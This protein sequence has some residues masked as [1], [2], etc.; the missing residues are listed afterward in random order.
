M[1]QRKN[2][3]FQ[4]GGKKFTNV[5]YLMQYALSTAEPSSMQPAARMSNINLECRLAP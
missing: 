2:L 4:A 3:D 1:G 5:L